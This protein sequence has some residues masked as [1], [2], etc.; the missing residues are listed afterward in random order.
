MQ[1]TMTLDKLR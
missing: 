1:A